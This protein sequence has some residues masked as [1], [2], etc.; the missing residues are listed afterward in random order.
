MDDPNV[1][2]FDF[3]HDDFGPTA[4]AFPFVS[5]ARREPD[6]GGSM[7]ST[8]LPAEGGAGAFASAAPVPLSSSA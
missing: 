3:D 4:P 7:A 8:L 5:A 6:S 2:P 1:D